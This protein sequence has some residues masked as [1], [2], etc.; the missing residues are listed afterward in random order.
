MRMLDISQ[1]YKSSQKKTIKKL[2]NALPGY[3]ETLEGRRM[4]S[5]LG[6][7]PGYP[8]IP[9]DTTT[10]TISYVYNSTSQEGALIA[11]GG[12]PSPV[13]LSPGVTD[14]ITSG[15]FSINFLVNGSGNVISGQ[16]GPNIVLSGNIPALGDSGT[17]LQ[18]TISN[19]G[20]QYNGSNVNNFDATFTPTGGALESYFTGQLIGISFLSQNN[21]FT[22][23][24]TTNWTAGGNNTQG[25]DGTAG[26][27]PKFL[28][29][30]TTS[31]SPTA[32]LANALP[33]KDTAHLTGGDSPTGNI[34]FNL[35]SPSNAIVDTEIVPVNGDNDYTTPNGYVPTL[36]GTYYWV[37]SY[38]GDT[39]N[40]PVAS[41]AQDEPVVVLAPAPA[42]PFI[43]TTQ[44]PASAI[45]GSAI[46]D[47]ATVSGGYSPT[48]TVTFNL[49]SN[50][51]GTGTPL[52]T[53]ANEPLVG[54]IA[55]SSGYIA[56]ATA[57]DY[58]VATYN[59]D[60]NNTSVTSSAASE[61]VTVTP[62]S[63]AINTSQQPAIAI[64]GSTIADQATVS[65]GFN[66][67]GTVTFNL[68]NNA[69]GTG[70]PLFTDANEP[71]VGGIATSS[72]YIATATAT[73]Y[74]VATYNGDSN[75]SSVTSGTALEPVSITPASP[76]INTTQQPASAI[77]GSAIADQATVSGG[78]SP[79]GTVT[80]NLYSN[81]TGTGT[82]LFTDA[83]E[84]LVGGVATSSGYI[85]AATATDYW[86]AT[87]NGDSNNSSVT[88]GTA[89]EPVT[90]T[91]ATPAINTTQQP[92]SAIV[93]SS[94][95][96]KATVT[97]GYSPTGTVTFNLYSNSTGTGTPLFTDANEPL[98]GG[99]ATSSG[100]IATA[101]AT[102]YWVATYNGDSNNS[103]VTSGTAL[104]PVSITPATPAINTSQQ[105]ATAIVGS[106]IADKATVS[107]GY[108]PSGTVTFNLYNNPN[109]T[110]TVLY[111][112]TETLSGGIATS[113]G[114]I[115]TAT[116]TDYWVATYNGDSNNSSVTSGTALEPVSITPATPAIN[117]AQQP[118]S[119][120][121][122]SSIADKATVSGG[123]SP[124]GTVTFN[125]YNNP[126]GTG[127][128]LFTDTETLSGGIATSK[129]YIATATATDYWV[130]TYN[131]DSNNSSVTSGTALEPV[132]ITPA[133]PS[134]NTQQ[135]P[136][137]AI[138]GSSI[139]DK[140]TVSGGYSPTGTVTFN[141]YSN[142]T[143][144][145]T[146]LV[147]DAN[148]A[149]VNGVATS[150][151]YTATA[152]GTDYWVATY[153]GDSNNSS[154]TSGTALEPVSI[155][156][157]S[158]TVVTS[159]SFKT[160]TCT[161]VGQAIPEDSAVV[162][163]GYLP[164][165]TITFTL[166][167][168]GGSVVD[169][170]VVNIAG[171]GTYSTTNTSVAT[172]VGTYTWSVSYSGDSNNNTAADQ[173][174]SAEQVTTTKSSP[175]VVTTASEKAGTSSI[176]GTAIPEDSAV[177]S[178]GYN[179]TGNLVFTLKAPNGTVADTQTI[180]ITG[181]GTYTTSNSNIA[182]QV[183][184]Y[185]WTVS[186]AGDISNNAANDQGGSAEQVTTT[187]ATLTVVTTA[188]EKSGTGATVGTAVPEDSAVVAGGFN[189]T[190]S[191]TFTLKSPTGT[192]V[193]TQTVT[194][195]GD[196]TY[197]T[198]NTV[199]AAA[200]GTYTWTAS[201]GGD[202]SNNT[203]SD[204]GGSAE[205]LVT[206]K[207]TPTITTTANKSG[208]GM[209]GSTT[210]T[211]S[212]VVAGGYDPTGSITFTLVDPTGATISTQNITI[213]GDGTYSPASVS[214]TK[215]GT[216][217]WHAVYSGDA[218]NTTA[219]DQG[220]TA[221][222]VTIG[223]ATPTVITTASTKSSTGSVVGTAIPE[224][225]AVVSGGDSPTGNLVFTL[226]AP[227]GT[228][229]DTQTIAITAD[230]TYATTNTAVATQV[231][232]YTWT[233][234]YNGDTLNNSAN[235]QGGSAEQVVTTKATPTITT[236]ASF[237]T[238]CGNMLGS[239]VP[240][241]SAVVAGGDSPTGSLT[242][243]L[244]AP[245][246]SVVDT[247]V[248]NITGDGSYATSNTVAATQTG[249]YTWAVTYSG[250]TLNNTAKDQGGSAEQL[251]IASGSISGTKFNDVTGNGFS[252]DDTP[253]SGVTIELFKSGG[254]SPI[255]TQ[256][257]DANGNYD[258]TGLAAGSYVVEEVVPTGW[259]Q[260][261]PVSGSYNVTLSSTSLTSTGN[262]FDDFMSSCCNT[263]DFTCVSFVVQ[264]AS[265][266]KTVSDLRGNTNQ[267][268]EVTAYFDYT[269]TTA[270]PVTF[271]TYTAPDNTYNASDASEQQEF[272]V[273]TIMAQPGENSIS[274]QIPNCN[275]QIDLV[276]GYAI[277]QLGP[278]NSNI[279]YSAQDR[280]ISA[281]ND[282]TEAQ[283][284]AFGQIN[285]NVY[286]DLN[287]NGIEDSN[288]VG[289]GGVT[290]ELTGKDTNGNAVSLLRLT[291]P[292][293][294]Y[295]FQGLQPGTYSVKEITPA[296]YTDGKDTLGTGAGGTVSNDL[297]SNVKVVSG[298]DG[299]NYNYG[300]LPGKA[301]SGVSGCT[302]T[303]TFWNGSNGSDLIC[304]FGSGSSDCTLGNWLAS[305]YSNLYG[306]SCGTNCLAGKTNA[307]IC[308]YFQGLYKNSSSKTACEVLAACL[309]LYATDASL[310]G[311]CGATYGFDVQQDGAACT[312]YSVGTNGSCFGVS[313]NTKCSLSDLI[314]AC[315]SKSSKGSLFGGNSSS[316]TSCYTVLSGINGW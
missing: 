5:L 80:F 148:V 296:G 170:Q 233:V 28:P 202:V 212:A 6:V 89:L 98:S 270:H 169:T 299:E 190:G 199:V 272:Q 47:Q 36:P 107:G 249:A 74:W 310:G 220:G 217:T 119:A 208:T 298:T 264:D 23:S 159:A 97:G 118:A 197:N 1:R 285:G 223:K 134:I 305:N 141:L 195:T 35:T 99:V 268:D 132:S 177:V 259:V 48:G 277:N 153:N 293:G 83:N 191:I 276:C 64:V 15:A 174:G 244:T 18:G 39:N 189:P 11:S 315:N 32:E 94:I 72:G 273:V 3:L 154:V 84:P 86:V 56:T 256:V 71:L 227:N 198:T 63:P 58:W 204:Q 121:V 161:V 306:S 165:G 194:I 19:F 114:Y 314:D 269:G 221:E 100:Y 187:K 216:Y 253:L 140:A 304:S 176:V 10:S 88:S 143:G 34:T 92:A 262:N 171:D 280:L 309:N 175:T 113:S 14:R 163:G 288:E 308:T 136:A 29:A 111:T 37:A 146:P 158:P 110:G 215:V 229:A 24:F 52:F 149:L 21:T 129:G 40:Q 137:T 178:G 247:Q 33:L 201:Y 186:Y 179:P 243:T 54:G 156:P 30:I 151:G 235:D 267:G 150:P 135:Q 302:A 312:T 263:A 166:K 242:F 226:K 234:S 257:T 124:T 240:E 254:T 104:E 157:A 16:A 78:Y 236:T 59:G 152:T 91:P 120:I 214:T 255:A 205:Q 68:F 211:D 281:D 246:G 239:G 43:N 316:S 278:A 38:S 81:S 31:A 115:A 185:T 117:T 142:S 155:T 282:G 46:A 123:Y 57:T 126:N 96:D 168:P 289:I 109:G 160:S 279:F 283:T 73:D 228:V 183:G 286:L 22:G 101:T 200:V 102:D 25:V 265:G 164:S 133:S 17:L 41:G 225:S 139:A 237:K 93:G 232:T 284:S 20:Y 260:T 147:T 184:T 127:T 4:L 131:G 241:D 128:V 65:G 301:C 167:A 252:S 79:T 103:S 231:G 13:T 106:S 145:G 213:N 230:G 55:T 248:V 70:T 207:A 203:A 182:T 12:I 188:S 130:A 44:Q 112:D 271:V 50:S 62:A 219:S 206:T 51:T 193:D 77:V 261:A 173:G 108:N 87:Y 192:T 258:F 292:D 144:T 209:C 294:T 138:V 291:N 287:N 266:V 85:A 26:P 251:V 42:V 66:P 162:S 218:D 53:D 172:V 122:G 7:S 311:L 61:P 250:D 297:F 76:S 45:V 49:Y 116:A 2:T 290:V 27:V 75:N 8:S 224:D 303:C 60:S 300:E 245:N 105:P 275:Y 180:A 69:N 274:V 210:I 95:A 238:G 82:P 196:G 67:S 9:L 295:S 181:D 222:Q 313:N 125:L 307:Q 90:I